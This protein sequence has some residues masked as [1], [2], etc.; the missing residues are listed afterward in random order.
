[1][2]ALQN[3]F[4]ALPEK[5]DRQDGTF[6]GRRRQGK[7]RQ[8]GLG[9]A[10]V[11]VM[12]LAPEKKSELA[13][14]LAAQTSLPVTQV[15]EAV[16]LKENNV[17][18]GAPGQA[19]LLEGNILVP[20]E[21]EDMEG[22][23]FPIDHF[24]RS[25]AMSSA[26]PIGVVLSGAGTDGSA[27]LRAIKEAGGLIAAQDPGEAQ[28]ESMPRSAIQASR[29]DLVL[30]TG[31]LARR[32]STQ[33]QIIGQLPR[34]V[35]QGEAPEG[36]VLK[37]E[38]LGEQGTSEQELEKRLQDIFEETL[39]QTG[40]DFRQYKRSTML[41]RIHRRLQVHELGSL[42]EYLSYLE[43]HSSEATAL[44][45]DCLISVTR[46][47][48]NPG[49][50]EALSEEVV[51][52][53]V[54]SA[55]ESDQIRA[56]TVGCATGEEAYSLAMTF[57]EEIESQGGS[58][59]Q[60]QIFASDL[61]EEA[62]AA[63]RKGRYPEAVTADV[64][65][66]YLKQ[67]FGKD[68]DERVV[69][70]EVRDQV[71]FTTHDLLSDP[72][73]SNLD[74]ISC[75]NLLIYLQQDLQENVLEVLGYALND[76]GFLF[77]GG[78]E[79]AGPDQESFETIDKS[80]RLYQRRSTA[81]SVPEL[82]S[83]PLPPSQEADHTVF[84]MGMAQIGPPGTEEDKGFPQGSSSGGFQ[85]AAT[86]RRLL[87][88]YAPP[89][90][91]V[92]GDYQLIH[93]SQ[94]VGRYLRQPGGTP[95]DNIVDLV[96]PGLKMK[97]R[98]ALRKAFEEGEPT[99]TQ[100]TGVKFGDETRPVRL[101]VQPA[102]GSSEGEQDA[103]SLALVLFE[104]TEKGQLEEVRPQED[105]QGRTA[106]ESAPAEKTEENDQS[107]D[108]QPDQGRTGQEPLSQET[109]VGSQAARL[110]AELERTKKE[111][112]IA[113][114]EHE[115]SKQ[116]M[117]AA[118]E[119]LRSMNEEYR[120]TAEELETS[121]EELQSVNEELKSVN[122]ELEEKVQALEEANADLENLM[123][124]TNIGTL[125]LDEKLQI[126]R[127]TPRI[128]E[129]FNVR[130]E[131]EGRPVGDL[132]HCLEYDQ[133]V[134]DAWRTVQVKGTETEM[135][136]DREVRSENGR[137]FLVRFYPYLTAE[138]EVAGAVGT[139]VDITRRKETEERLRSSN[140]SLEERTQQV[141]N[142]TR[143]LTSA[144]EDERERLSEMLHGRIQQ[145]LV[146]ARLQLSDIVSD[147]ESSLSPDH[148]EQIGSII[149]L[150][151]QGAKTARSLSQELDPPVDGDSLPETLEWLARQMK[152]SYNLDVELTHRDNRRSVDRS[153]QVL[154]FRSVR[155]LLFNTVK[156]A[157]VSEASLT[158]EGDGDHLRVT[159]KDDGEGFDTDALG[160]GNGGRGLISVRDRI[161]MIGG[162]F[163]VDSA[164][165]EGTRAV[166]KVPWKV[167][168]V[169]E[170]L[171]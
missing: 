121:K 53:I 49:A 1:M 142:L 22:H 21:H 14:I 13:Q 93:L 38:D 36:E 84:G 76:D 125:F 81:R 124:T 146:G 100:P 6:E 96:R 37:E 130:P 75:R 24:F 148:R 117:Q 166:I 71:L 30:P 28:H 138:N 17:Y 149:D 160:T 136:V 51:P 11:V 59:S 89:S 123:A 90:V 43:E 140:K 68:G 151:Q 45:R 67:F 83:V 105:P 131:D 144:E 168:I 152:S 137:W 41:R 102:R 150:L 91:V 8:E 162:T 122:R 134:E 62:L 23:Q 141:I 65:D 40:H 164:P 26:E 19:L 50:F 135:V 118:N 133:L 154:I 9:F 55:A 155:E 56:W 132:T 79:S 116:E 115:A 46:F 29:A 60:L 97:L 167:D 110:E 171:P 86:H 73:F 48:R 69:R 18:V 94:N 92:G 4:D 104:E 5:G 103:S 158:V 63:A 106:S 34:L 31:E 109:D 113:I 153:L 95:S 107:E 156:H 42:S 78:S 120:S 35:T 111:L 114:E 3:F 12:H 47:F 7:E 157:G 129:L 2:S 52:E 27:G 32:L 119:E 70:P 99:E 85:K 98:S 64:P 54:S 61:D 39:R 80:N 139:F 147:I 15:T 161:E 126:Q 10:I 77:L 145:T 163:Q 72:P 101:L 165:G 58:A 169:K 82:P 88:T 159:V 33:P 20:R 87:E 170:E 44:Q 128:E 25:L 74:M 108:G 66:R 127:Y 16:S 57:L 112:R 143:A